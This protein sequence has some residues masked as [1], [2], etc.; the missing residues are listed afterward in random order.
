M[1]L[2]MRYSG[3]LVLV[4]A[5]FALEAVA[6]DLDQDEALKLREEGVIMPLEQ[7]LHRALGLYPGARLLEAELEEEDDVYV[8]EVELLTTEGVVRELELDAR[9]GRILKDEEDD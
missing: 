1:G 4:L 9:D 6:R 7:L 8:Y 2:I 5:V 3:I